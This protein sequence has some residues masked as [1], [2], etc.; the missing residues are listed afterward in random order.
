[1]EQKIKLNEQEMDK[2][3]ELLKKDNIAI[4][5]VAMYPMGEVR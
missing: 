4:P 1:M 2:L 3:C 5:R